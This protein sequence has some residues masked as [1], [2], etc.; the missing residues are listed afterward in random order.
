MRTNNRSII[1]YLRGNKEL[2]GN[3][4]F[5]LPTKIIHAHLAVSHNYLRVVDADCHFWAGLVQRTKMSLMQLRI[6]YLLSAAY[7]KK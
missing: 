2:M 6:N 7:L 1:E 4:V 5:C 3:N